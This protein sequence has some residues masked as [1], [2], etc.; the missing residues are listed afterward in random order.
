MSA[1]DEITTLI[2]RYGFTIDTGDKEGFAELFEHGEWTV[3]GTPPNRGSDEV[4]AAIAGVQIYEDGT[5]RTKHMTSN[6]E[7]DIDEDAGTASGQCY[8]AVFQ[9]T[10][11]FPLQPIFIAHYFD[12]FERADGAWRFTKRLIRH[13]LVGDLSHHLA[14]PGDVVSGA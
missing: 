5:P 10:D 3:E 1:R 6:V 13:P 11:D 9:Q 4:L 8:V 2:N 14:T 7:L 12:E